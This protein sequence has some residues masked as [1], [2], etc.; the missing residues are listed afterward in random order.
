MVPD[1]FTLVI[2]GVA[3]I[4]SFFSPCI[5]P[6]I[7]AYLAHLAGVSVAEL[8][9][10]DSVDAQRRIIKHAL[11]F[12]IGFAGIFIALGSSISLLAQQI[13]GFQILLSRVGGFII[14]VFGMYTMR[15]FPSI[16]LLEK[17]YRIHSLNQ[18]TG[19]IGSL[20]IGASFGIGWTPCVGP[21]LASILVLAGSSSTVAQGTTLLFVFSLGLAIPFLL[22]GLF[23][24]K[25]SR[26]IKRLNRRLGVIN[27]ISGMLL[28]SLGIVVFTN[29]FTRVL[30]LVL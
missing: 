22:V 29:N 14:I 6:M 9:G 28:I 1:P 4:L 25:S 16:P 15:L 12:V 5:V 13:S 2:A 11:L 17:E 26:L 21:V 30:S 3:G 20:F 18:G 8:D 19:Y 27:I 10:S 24:A 7:P 23:T